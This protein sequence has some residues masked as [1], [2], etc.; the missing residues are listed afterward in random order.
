MDIA[1]QKINRAAAAMAVSNYGHGTDEAR[2]LRWK[3]NPRFPS[4]PRSEVCDL[5][6]HLMETDE[7][8]EMFASEA[9]GWAKQIIDAGGLLAFAEVFHWHKPW[10]LQLEAL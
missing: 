6:G 9:D 1:A 10:I 4:T 5:A 8:E 7:H 3:P 2:I